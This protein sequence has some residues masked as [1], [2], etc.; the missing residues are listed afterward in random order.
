MSH[1]PLAR[2]FL[3]LARPRQV[4]ARLLAFKNDL[5]PQLPCPA[6]QFRM[7]ACA[8]GA[9]SNSTVGKLLKLNGPLL[10]TAAPAGAPQH[11]AYAQSP[12]RIPFSGSQMPAQ[13][14]A[15]SSMDK[16]ELCENR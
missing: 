2:A 9:P 12:G 11:W 14:L 16:L 7:P 5:I 6:S 4:N 8:S 10:D 13:P 1:H 3:G 15:W